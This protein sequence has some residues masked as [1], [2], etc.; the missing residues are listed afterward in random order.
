MRMSI[1]RKYENEMQGRPQTKQ[2]Q[3]LLGILCEAE[4]HMDAKEL[5]KLA[6]NKDSSISPATVY[7]NLNLF[8][9]LGLIDEKR[10]GQSH[11]YYEVKHATQHQ[12]LVCSGCG[13][14]IDFECP[15]SEIVARVKREQGFMVTKAEVYFEG[16]CSECTAKNENGEKQASGDSC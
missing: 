14:V 13:K 4:G 6:V 7:R 16:Y 8:K 11:C 12:H 2:R 10:L 5:F 9:Q 3:L 1:N 15:L